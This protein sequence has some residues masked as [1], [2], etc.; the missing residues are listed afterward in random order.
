MGRR[1]RHRTSNDGDESPPIGVVG[2]KAVVLLAVAILLAFLLFYVTGLFE[3]E[4]E[5]VGTG[6]SDREFTELKVP[7]AAIYPCDR[8]DCPDAENCPGDC[9]CPT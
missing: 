5:P 9:G 2:W 3:S 7:Q 1:E 8:S 4:D 6:T